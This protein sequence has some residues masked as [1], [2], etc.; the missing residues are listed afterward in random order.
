[1]LADVFKFRI[2]FIAS[3]E[4]ILKYSCNHPAPP[5]CGVITRAAFFY[6]GVAWSPIKLTLLIK[7]VLYECN[8]TLRALALHRHCRTNK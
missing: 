2:N 7:Y 4:N 1:M 8:C 3:T 6:S 5:W